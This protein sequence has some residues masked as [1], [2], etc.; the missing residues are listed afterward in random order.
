MPGQA[1]GRRG[2]ARGA[3]K[4]QQLIAG[5]GAAPEVGEEGGGLEAQAGLGEGCGQA[6]ENLGAALVVPSGIGG[7]TDGGKSARGIRVVN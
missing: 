7:S 2:A 1:R 6:A 3:T 4:A 5:L